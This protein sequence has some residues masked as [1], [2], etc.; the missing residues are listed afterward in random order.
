MGSRRWFWMPEASALVT[1]VATLT[2]GLPWVAQ[3]APSTVAPTSEVAWTVR[4]ADNEH[5]SDRPNFSY[6]AQPGSRLSD[7][8]EVS[9]TGS[10][11]LTLDVYAADAFTTEAGAIDVGLG[12]EVPTDAGAWVTTDVSA[13]QLAPGESAVIPFR[14]D[15]PLDARPGDHSAGLVTVLPPG[16]ADALTLERRLGTR[17][18]VEVPGEST[19]SISLADARLTYAVSWL[20]LVP[21]AAELTYR[22]TNEGDAVLFVRDE[23]RIAGPLGI[24]PAVVVP[25]APVEVLPGSTV[26]VTRTV[27]AHGVGWLFAEADV[28]TLLRDGSSEG[29]SVRVVQSTFALSPAVALLV[30]AVLGIGV[31]AV[32]RH[33]RRTVREPS[34]TDQAT[35]PVGRSG[36][37]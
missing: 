21:G 30:L 37:P 1:L 27:D 8:M 5:G 22:V 19:P 17:I 7:A 34:T 28:T 32:V 2:L 6:V 9:N 31:G 29:P 23:A 25:A 24:L 15:V 3:A 35:S 10:T 20:P 12:K 14:I 26:V 18:T 11:A 13:L 33:R 4:T 36:R 16:A